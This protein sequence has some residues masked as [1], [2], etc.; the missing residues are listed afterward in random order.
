MPVRPKDFHGLR[1]INAMSPKSWE[2]R[3]M[4]SNPS[5]KPQFY[6]DAL[7]LPRAAAAYPLIR[8]IS[9]ELSLEGWLDY[10]ERRCRH[11][12]LMGLFGAGG[13]VTG[14]FSYRLGERLAG[15]VLAL[16][17]FV[18]FEL[19]RAA[20]GRAA[21]IAA[22]EALGRSLGCVAMEVRTGARGIADAA[23]PR[24]LGWTALGM[25]LDSAVFV[26]AL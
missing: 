21:M 26:K 10:A 4:A 5:F 13:E 2:N 12:G 18:T 24:A 11:G 9:P 8:A 17:D 7:G 22:A 3:Y 20:P 6:V 16:D 23:G 25:R 14:L 15:R 19:S 1:Q